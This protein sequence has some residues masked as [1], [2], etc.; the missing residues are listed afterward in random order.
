MQKTL[1][2][3]LVPGGR[4]SVKLL[5]G[6]ISRVAPEMPTTL[7]DHGAGPYAGPPATL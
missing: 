4:D 3:Y 1:P 7:R 6:Y 2:V 5:W